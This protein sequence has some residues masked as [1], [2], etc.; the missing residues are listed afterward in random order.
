MPSRR[1]SFGQ[2]TVSLA[3][4]LNLATSSPGGFGHDETRDRKRLYGAH[5]YVK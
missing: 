4:R 1:A 5:P 2:I 3:V